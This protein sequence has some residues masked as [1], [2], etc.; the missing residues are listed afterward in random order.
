MKMCNEVH[1][2]MYLHYTGTS[3]FSDYCL[4]YALYTK[5][6]NWFNYSIKDTKDLYSRLQCTKQA[7]R[8]KINAYLVVQDI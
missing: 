7:K 5:S 4:S 3:D 6:T 1:S 2:Y 8:M